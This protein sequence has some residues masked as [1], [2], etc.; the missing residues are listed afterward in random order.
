MSLSFFTAVEDIR[1]TA[2]E[3]RLPGSRKRFLWTT[4]LAQVAKQDACDGSLGDLLLDIIR[5]FKVVGES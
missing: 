1:A 2:T 5:A 3:Y 4:I